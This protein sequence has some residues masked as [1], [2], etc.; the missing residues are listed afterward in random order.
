MI[1]PRKN[2]ERKFSMPER[3]NAIAIIITNAFIFISLS[4]FN[5]IIKNPPI[6]VKTE[7]DRRN[8]HIF[9]L[10][11]FALITVWSLNEPSIIKNKPINIG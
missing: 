7:N 1:F 3:I 11:L 6:I 10:Y 4:I 5:L 9:S 8:H 2:R